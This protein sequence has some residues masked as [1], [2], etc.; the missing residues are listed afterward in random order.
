MNDLALLA[1]VWTLTLT[2]GALAGG[3]IGWVVARP[4]KTEADETQ[5]GLEVAYDLG[6]GDGYRDAA[7]DR[8]LADF[9]LPD[10]EA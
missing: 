10:G 2:V 1:L 9:E 6:Y 7:E 8:T 5:L 3:I 4:G